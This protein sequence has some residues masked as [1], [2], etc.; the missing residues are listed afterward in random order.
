MIIIKIIQLFSSFCNIIQ[1]FYLFSYFKTKQKLI[2]IK[3]KYETPLVYAVRNLR[4]EIVKMLLEYGADTY[5]T[6]FDGISLQN[7]ITTEEIHLLLRGIFS[8]SLHISFLF[9][10]YSLYSLRNKTTKISIFFTRN[11]L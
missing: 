5:I 3:S 6:T 7:I 1:Q 2:M 11:S 9:P 4:S 10:F 8:S